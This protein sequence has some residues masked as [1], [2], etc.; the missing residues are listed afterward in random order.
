MSFVPWSSTRIFQTGGPVAGGTLRPDAVFPKVKTVEVE[1]STG[2]LRLSMASSAFVC[3]CCTVTGEVACGENLVIGIL[4]GKVYT[5][6]DLF[7]CMARHGERV[8]VARSESSD[9]GDAWTFLF[10]QPPP[11]PPRDGVLVAMIRQNDEGSWKVCL[12]W[13]QRFHSKDSLVH[14]Q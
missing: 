14:K 8:K 13:L 12:A 5:K 6:T 3:A 7:E 9:E 1:G 10:R 4:E 2:V 11:P